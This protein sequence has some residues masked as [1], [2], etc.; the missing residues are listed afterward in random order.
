MTRVGVISDV[1]SNS[2]SLR[3]ILE[4]IQGKVDLI[5]SCGDLVGYGFHPNEVIDMVKENNITGIAGNHD[6]GVRYHY[7]V[8][9]YEQMIQSLSSEKLKELGKDLQFLRLFMFNDW[10]QKMVETNA[11]WLTMESS[12]YLLKLERQMDLNID[13]QNIKMVHGQ[14]ST[15]I[16]A[17]TGDYLFFNEF[18][19]NRELRSW[20]KNNFANYSLVLHGHTHQALFVEI[21]DQLK[22]KKYWTK[23]IDRKFPRKFTLNDNVMTFINPGSAGI[24]RDGGFPNVAILDLE[25]QEIT[26]HEVKYEVKKYLTSITEKKLRQVPSRVKRID[27]WNK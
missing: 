22:I 9:H 3:N 1:H 25:E 24:P 6:L 8:K 11:D 5:L 27:F 17:I 20:M 19:F 26:F 7:F 12:F 14:P 15:D 13:G 18:K 2:H 4:F 21:D 23:T 16:H 10:A